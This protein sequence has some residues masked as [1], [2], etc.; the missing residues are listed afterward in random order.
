MECHD[1]SPQLTNGVPWLTTPVTKFE[2]VLNQQGPD[3][4]LVMC[5][6]PR[7]ISTSIQ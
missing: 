5:A 3:T 2:E 1:S 7:M 4:S 6:S